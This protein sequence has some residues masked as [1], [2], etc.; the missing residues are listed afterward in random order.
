M[1]MD[2]VSWGSSFGLK[3]SLVITFSISRRIG[4]ETRGLRREMALYLGIRWHET[5]KSA[6]STNAYMEELS[7]EYTVKKFLGS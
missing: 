7:R 5:A 3:N 1:V 4:G 2:D 6:I